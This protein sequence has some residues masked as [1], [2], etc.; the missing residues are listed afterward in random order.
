M[1]G[2]WNTAW[3]H[4]RPV[5]ED[6]RP[7]GGFSMFS[8][9]SRLLSHF[10]GPGLRKTQDPKVPES[11]PLPGPHVLHPDA[12]TEEERGKLLQQTRSQAQRGR[13]RG[14]YG[15]PA[16]FNGNRDGSCPGSES[17]LTAH[18]KTSRALSAP[19][20]S[21]HASS[22]QNPRPRHLRA[23]QEPQIT[24]RDESMAAPRKVCLPACC[25]QRPLDIK[26]QPDF[27]VGSSRGIGFPRV[28]S[29]RRPINTL[30]GVAAAIA[31]RLSW[32]ISSVLVSSP[33]Q[34]TRRFQFIG[35]SKPPLPATGL[36]E[37]PHSQKEL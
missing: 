19:G 2:H 12:K 27:D 22:L 3:A 35:E 37:D 7:L 6:P 11:Q 10:T 1:Y 29:E 15:D 28:G 30:R 31:S 34:Q 14:R 21:G 36:A 8:P 16:P 32:P 25:P 13:R 5:T 9:I 18:C 23:A 24:N 17:W 4:P 33:G 20:G 26:Q